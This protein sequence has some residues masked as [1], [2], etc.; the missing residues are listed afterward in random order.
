MRR[1]AMTHHDG[2]SSGPLLGQPLRAADYFT[3]NAYWFALSFLWNSMGPILLPTMVPLLVPESQKGGALGILSACGLIVAIVVQPLAGAWSDSHTTR[4]GRR[5]PFLV[6]GTLADV[7][8][9]LLMATAGNYWVLLVGYLLLQT[10]SNIAHGPYQGY[11]PD[12]VPLSKRG[13]VT[14]VKQFLEILGIIA[15][16]LAVGN[17]VAAG[18][19][20]AAFVAIIAFLLITMAI[21]ALT[22]TERPFLG[23][24]RPE[25][26]PAIAAQTT[27]GARGASRGVVG[28]LTSLFCSRDF[29]LWLVSRLLI[30]LGGNLVR[31]YALYFLTDVLRLPNPAAEVGNL[32]AIIAVA[33]AVVVYP[34]GVLS[35][36]WGRKPL[37]IVSGALGAVGALLLMTASSLQMVLIDGAVIGVSIG[38]FLSVNWAWGADLIPSGEGGRFL[39]ISNIATAGSG[40]L[41]G[42]GGI[43]L[44]YFNAQSVNMGYPIL[45]G[46]AAVCYVLGTLVVLGVRDVRAQRPA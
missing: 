38:I 27:A 14:G 29:V 22:V 37:V 45:F 39:G 5:R 28:F 24:E 31:N 4:W 30:L 17:L 15:T 42:L 7:V 13:A 44:D 23:A 26:A 19:I 16:S 2:A 11:I 21:S 33:I 25:T 36:R 1:I 46:S 3:L 18:Q 20:V 40:V 35:D 12:L 8:F 34:A 9:L 43:I 32:L 41:A 6:G 10:S